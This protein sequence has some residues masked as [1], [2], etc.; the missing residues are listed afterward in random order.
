MLRAPIRRAAFTAHFSRPRPRTSFRYNSTGPSPPP[1][2][3]SN[4]GLL[5]GLGIAALGGVGFYLYTS[6]TDT[7]KGA[8]SAPKA[9]A[10]FKPTPEDYQKVCCQVNAMHRQFT[11][12][13]EFR[14]I[15][16]LLSF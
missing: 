6:N 5:A 10:S 12:N 9:K 14:F 4:L 3:K 11:D 15:T 8:A 16:G 7:A 2:R 13:E 1:T